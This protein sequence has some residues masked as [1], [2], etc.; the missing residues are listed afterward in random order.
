MVFFKYIFFNILKP[1]ESTEELTWNVREKIV[2][3]R[4]IWQPIIVE[5]MSDCQNF[6]PRKILC[7]IFLVYAVNWEV[8]QK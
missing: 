7:Y 4:K 6:I 1:L 5:K 3:W 8:K 2:S